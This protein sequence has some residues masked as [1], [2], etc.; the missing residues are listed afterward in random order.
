M[1]HLKQ[2][3]CDQEN[4]SLL[5]YEITHLKHTNFD[6]QTTWFFDVLDREAMNEKLRFYSTILDILVKTPVH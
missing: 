5:I 6:L 3:N 4:Y 1:H 2:S